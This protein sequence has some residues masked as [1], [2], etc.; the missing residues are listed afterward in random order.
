MLCWES[1]FYV[2]KHHGKHSLQLQQQRVQKLCYCP[3]SQEE[4]F[5]FLFHGSSCWLGLLETVV[6]EHQVTLNC[7]SPETI[8]N[9]SSSV[10][11]LWLPQTL[12]EYKT[13]KKKQEK[14]WSLLNLHFE[15]DVERIPIP[16]LSFL[17][18]KVVKPFQKHASQY[19]LLRVKVKD[20]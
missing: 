14:S 4:N 9:V 17:K 1:S 20:V 3:T 5:S 8:M 2:T 15:I 7:L 19:F 13:W 11:L 12:K 16:C 18:Q 10:C 6:N